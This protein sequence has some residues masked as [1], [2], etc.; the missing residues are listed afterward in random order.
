MTDP[1]KYR[2][3]RESGTARWPSKGAQRQD[4]QRNGR[5]AGTGRYG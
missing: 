4:E 1:A 3:R 5:C 2:M